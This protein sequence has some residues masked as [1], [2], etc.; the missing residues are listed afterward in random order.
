MSP[1]RATTR[2]AVQIHVGT[3]PNHYS[4]SWRIRRHI[5]QDRESTIQ[6]EN[7]QVVIDHQSGGALADCL[8]AGP[9]IRTP[10][11]KLVASGGHR[12]FGLISY[13]S[14]NGT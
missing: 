7:L 8:S 11:E 3:T 12:M 2:A 4:R 6:R 13:Q 9:L 5:R 1:A 10:A 14:R